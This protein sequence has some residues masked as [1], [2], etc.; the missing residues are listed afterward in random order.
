MEV[1]FYLLP[2]TSYINK[3]T[4]RDKGLKIKVGFRD[5]LIAR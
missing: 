5:V 4:F 1:E 2:K 3:T